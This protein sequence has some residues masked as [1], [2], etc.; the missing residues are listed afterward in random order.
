[1]SNPE[2]TPEACPPPLMWQD[3]RREYLAQ[4]ERREIA[5]RHGTIAVHVLGTGP[6]L[7]FLPGFSTPSE[8][9]CLLIWLLRDEF[10][11]VVVEHGSPGAKS[12]SDH[13]ERLADAAH[14]LGDEGF[15]IFGANFGAAWGLAIAQRYPERVSRLM[16]LQ[17]FLRRRLS[18]FE[19]LLGW[20][21]GRSRRTLAELPYREAAQTQN[22]RRW[23]PPFDE[24]RW[25]YF[26]ETSGVLPL[27]ELS[28]RAGAISRFNL[29]SRAAEIRT[30][31]LLI[32]TE[33]DG[34]VAEACNRQLEQSL[35]CVSSEWLHNTGQ[36][37][38]LTH[39]HRLAKLMR[40]FCSES[41]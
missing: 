14:G 24:T 34:A 15:S 17:G 37:A 36:L 13:A 31:T 1:M 21:C 7:Y 33:G 8:L 40:T 38:Y 9:Y 20:M 41:P 23:F 28:E 26:L 32:H 19:R 2:V 5:T 29:V 3:V 25:N 22:Q 30:P 18:A 39:P 10:R 27:K 4:S 12:M 11:C 6:A 35:P 16:L